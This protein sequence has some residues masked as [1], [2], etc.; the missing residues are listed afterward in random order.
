[1]FW[2][3]VSLFLIYLYCKQEHGLVLVFIN[4]L[5]NLGVQTLWISTVF[6][7][8]NTIPLISSAKVY[9]TH[10]DRPTLGAILPLHIFL[11]GGYLGEMSIVKACFGTRW[12]ELGLLLSICSRLY[13][14][15]ICV[16]PTAGQ[17]E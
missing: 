4:F 5:I 7:I 14:S 12:I 11:G 15:A 13:V 6:F 9:A 8:F 2:R 17:P 16:L 10:L 3:A 1:M